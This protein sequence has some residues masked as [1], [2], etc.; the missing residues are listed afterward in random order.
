M[1]KL[2]SMILVLGFLL[3]GN[4]YAD[5]FCEGF[6]DGF[7]I[8]SSYKF[9]IALTPLCPLRPLKEIGDPSDDYGHGFNVGL[10]EACEGDSLC[11]GTNNK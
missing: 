4:A 5:S 8:G 10:R 1:K 3:S 11:V 6:Y 7:K 2:F 9:K